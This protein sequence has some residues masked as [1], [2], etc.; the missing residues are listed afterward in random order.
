MELRH[1]TIQWVG[2]INN[3]LTKAFLVNNSC[4]LN[5]KV[6]NQL[7]KDVSRYNLEKF[8]FSTTTLPF[9]CTGVCS[10]I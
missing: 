8:F 9:I 5:C 7:F 3:W 2:I 1:L 6:Q 10:T 4:A